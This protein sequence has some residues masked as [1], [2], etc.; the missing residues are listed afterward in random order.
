MITSIQKF[1]GQHVT[2]EQGALVATTY[3]IFS[4]QLFILFFFY[5]VTDSDLESINLMPRLCCYKSLV[6]G[7]CLC[8][9]ISTFIGSYGD[10]PP[11]IWD[12]DFM[13][14]PLPLEVGPSSPLTAPALSKQTQPR[15]H[16]Q[17]DMIKF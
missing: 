12:C 11:F 8:Y 2:D 7:A 16:K 4:K 5:H 17:P 15:A 14:L 13:R 3:I 10:T 6:C 1:Q 9:D